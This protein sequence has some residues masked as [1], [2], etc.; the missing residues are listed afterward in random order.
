[1]FRSE[2][3]EDREDLDLLETPIEL[4]GLLNE[5]NSI[6]PSSDQ[7]AQSILLGEEE[8]TLEALMKGPG[9]Y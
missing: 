4:I 5:C 1:M 3:G 8:E 6:D 9:M 2:K 7:D